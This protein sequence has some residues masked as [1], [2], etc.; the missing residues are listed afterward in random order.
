MKAT[1]NLRV[2]SMDWHD[3]DDPFSVPTASASYHRLGAPLRRAILRTREWLLSQ[4]QA[5]GHWVGELE[6]D[7]I[8]ESEFILLLAYLGRERS[9]LAIKAAR[10]LVEKQLPE[11][12]W[13][14]Y[15]GGAVDISVSVKAYFALKLTGHDAGQPY[16]QRARRAIRAG[17]GADRVN[18]FTRFY[19]ALLGQIDWRHTPAVPPEAVLL[20]RWFPINLSRVSAWSRTILVPLSVISAHRP[21]RRLAPELGIRELFL[22]EP[23]QWPLLSCP[24][25]TPGGRLVSWDRFFRLIDRGLKLA[26]KWRFTPLRKRALQ[27]AERWMLQRFEESDGLGA[28]FPPIVWSVVALECQGYA[29]DSEPVQRC[30]KEL[31]ELVIEESHTARLQPCKSP[32]WDTALSL[33]SLSASGLPAEHA[34]ACRATSW[35]LDK[36][37]RRPGDWSETVQAEPSGWFFEYHNTFYPDLDDTAMVLLALREQTQSTT[38]CAG[39]GLPPDLQLT[40]R[41][42]TRRRELSS[43]G[44]SREQAVEAAV[45]RAIRWTLAMQNRDGGWGAFDRDNDKEFLCHVP[46]AD[47]NAMIDPSTPDITGR[48]LEAL[49]GWGY[50]TGHAAVD[51]AVEYLRHTQEA[52]GSWLGRW[53]VNYIYG[54]WQALAGLAAVGVAAS[55]STMQSGAQWLLAHQQTSGGWGESP[56]SYADDRL[57]G[58]GPVTASQTAWALLGLLAAGYERHPAVARAVRYLVDTQEEDGR[59]DE[60]EF[61]GTGFPQVFYL[62]YHMYPIYFPL[63]ALSRWS[64]S[65]GQL[66]E[67]TDAVCA[68]LTEPSLVDAPGQRPVIAAVTHPA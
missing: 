50:R 67:S 31:H 61:T 63:L 6:G 62:R 27:A 68:Q 17:G 56:D 23:D 38:F 14:L 52:D 20:P 7:T 64:A 45:Q 12:G 9:P 57:R 24:G 4:Q 36:E 40:E 5:D 59:W 44:R 39:S 41:S 54:T 47:H 8:L 55:D 25:K 66:V 16:M 51:R 53:G 13:N 10:Y 18:S 30:L 33:R 29:R 19:L 32:V 22:Q 15:P 21:V 28:I 65:I 37:V 58:E 42:G 46:F 60:S 43:Q 34:A 3:Q 49:A 26:Q 11:G 48:V 1:P 35:L 2:V